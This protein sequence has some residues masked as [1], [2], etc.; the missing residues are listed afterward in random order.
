MVLNYRKGV[1]RFV[2]SVHSNAFS[3][4]RSAYWSWNHHSLNL[5]N[6]NQQCACIAAQSVLRQVNRVVSDPVLFVRICFTG[7]VCGRFV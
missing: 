7:G 3:P 6:T 2:V 5:N 1:L 4:V